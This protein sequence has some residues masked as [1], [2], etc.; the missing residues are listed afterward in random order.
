M[1]PHTLFLCFWSSKN[2]CSSP[3]SASND[4]KIAQF[5]KRLG[6]IWCVWCKGVQCSVMRE[7]KQI[8]ILKLKSLIVASLLMESEEIC[9]VLVDAPIRFLI[10][11]NKSGQKW[12]QFLASFEGIRKLSQKKKKK[13]KNLTSRHG[14]GTWTKNYGKKPRPKHTN[15][16][17]EHDT[18]YWGHET[19]LF[20]S[21]FELRVLRVFARER[22]RRERERRTG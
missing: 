11:Q 1:N 4:V 17:R 5:S 16:T 13:E 2:I 10:T 3:P 9:K 18:T 6:K 22:E 19:L 14:V 15:E 12:Q 20:P 21:H 8:R 7:L